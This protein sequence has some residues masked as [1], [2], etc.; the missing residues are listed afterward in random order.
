ML[1]MRK[2]K[3][4]LLVNLF[5]FSVCFTCAYEVPASPSSVCI[6]SEGCT[7]IY[8]PYKAELDVMIGGKSIPLLQGV[9]PVWKSNGKECSIAT[10]TVSLVEITKNEGRNTFIYA[11]PEDIRWSLTLRQGSAG[12]V[13]FDLKSEHAG[14]LKS[15]PGS[16]IAGGKWIGLDLNQYQTA[17]GQTNWPKTFYLCNHDLFLCAWW[18]W[19]A[20]NAS[21]PVWPLKQCE[22]RTGKRAFAPAA[23]MLYRPCLDGTFSPLSD[24]LHVRV[25]P[26][27]WKAALP[28]LCEPSEYRKELSTMVYLDL[29][30]GETAAGKKHILTCLSKLAGDHVRFLTIV[31]N[32]QTAGFDA[33]LPDSI[34]MPEYP[35]SPAKGTVD[36]Y[37]ELSELG[38]SLG[39]IGF[40]TNYALFCDQAPSVLKGIVAQA[41]DENGKSKWHTQPAKW[42]TLARR[43]EKEIAD[44]W[45]PNASFTDQL[46]SGACPQI[47]MDY[48]LEGGGGST[49]ASTLRHQRELARL[50]KETHKGPL[51][52]ETLNQQD[53]IGRYCDFGD[54]GCMNGHNRFFPPDYKLQRLQ[55]L[56]MHYGCGLAYRFFEASPFKLFHKQALDIWEDP[57]LMDDYRC[58]E[59]MLGNGA[60]IFWKSPW[61]WAVTESILI[62]RLQRYYALEPV[63]SVD[64]QVNGSWRSLEDLVRNGFAPQGRPWLQK[65]KE[66]ARIRIMYRNGLT[67]Y[68][69]R[70]PGELVVDVPD[71]KLTLPQYGWVAYMP[72]A[73]LFAYSALMP[74]TEHRVDCLEEKSSGLRFLNPRGKRIHDSTDV[75]LWQDGKLLWSLDPKND[76]VDV[77]GGKLQLTEVEKPLKRADINFDFRK[78]LSGWQ[79][80]RGILRIESVDQ[81]QRLV[82]VSKDPYLFSPV[83][84][85]EGRAGDVIEITLSSDTGTMGQF[86]FAASK[87]GLHM[88]SFKVVPDGKLHT[89]SIP[90][91]THNHWKDKTITRLRLDPVHG[92]LRSTVVLKSFH[93][94]RGADTPVDD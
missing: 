21:S 22:P 67:V 10:E 7:Y 27:L 26:K 72:D 61:A 70:L 82:V 43:Q 34:W 9:G 8:N 77:N 83:V 86:Y 45:Q 35:P 50:I 11:S 80:T 33:L 87:G 23:S 63:K 28:S 47:Y 18:D 92:P 78:G 56:T 41:T 94:K 62:G 64:Y 14:F 75:R 46:G 71:A 68:V 52:T 25:S 6:E 30:G 31:Q 39:L 57:A 36:E 84:E 40:R 81:G 60:Y 17:H 37:R 32:W 29:W 69:N 73:S 59:V 49:I 1:N 51:G 65:Q 2:I 13:V 44:L 55:P 38:K 88:R 15:Q 66:L 24:S 93:L 48:K 19:S 54:Y 4:V 90:I 85:F 58:C 12:D 76:V 5:A 53:L 20:S 3:I 74:G 79:A 16:V 89:V 91:G 42:T